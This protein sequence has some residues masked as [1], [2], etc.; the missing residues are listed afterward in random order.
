MKRIKLYLSV[1][2]AMALF[3]LFGIN[4][5]AAYNYEE[6]YSPLNSETTFVDE[7]KFDNLSVGDKNN[8]ANYFLYFLR[9]SYMFEVTRNRTIIGENNYDTF[10]T[11][12]NFQGNVANFKALLND[13]EYFHVVVKTT[14]LQTVT[15]TYNKS[16]DINFNDYLSNEY[17]N[18]DRIK[19]LEPE[20]IIKNYSSKEINIDDYKNYED[21]VL[22]KTYD[23]CE[24]YE[25]TD[26]PINLP[27]REELLNK[28]I[29]LSNG[30]KIE[31]DNN[32]I[33]GGNY[34]LDN[35]GFINPG[36]YYLKI[37]TEKNYK[38]YY[39]VYKINV[40]P[41]PTTIP[42]IYTTTYRQ[43]TTDEINKHLEDYDITNYTYD[44]S[45][46]L[47]Y[48][49]IPGSYYIDIN[50]KANGKNISAKMII[51]VNE[52]ND[53]VIKIKDN[54]L[55][56]IGYNDELDKEE[57]ENNIDFSYI[58]LDS[59]EIDYSEY[60]NNHDQIGNYNIYLYI[61]SKDGIDYIQ[62]SNIEIYDNICPS[63][64]LDDDIELTFLY[65]D[66]I[67]I[68]KI[69]ASLNIEDISDYRIIYDD[70]EFINREILIGDFTI[71]VNIIDINENNIMFPINIHVID[72]TSPKVIANNMYTTTNVL[73]DLN[74]IKLNVYAKDEID[75]VINIDNIT[76]NDANGYKDNY[77]L[78]GTYR[79]EAIITD[80]SGNEAFASFN[81]IVS[82][83]EEIIQDNNIIYI[84]KNNP[85]SKDEIIS[86]LKEK[87]YIDI[88]DEYN[89]SSIYFEC[90]TYD[91]DSYELEVENSKHEKLYFEIK[92]N[93]TNVL[94]DTIVEDDLEEDSG[95][96]PIIIIVVIAS[97]LVIASGILIFVIYKK[98]H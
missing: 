57:F 29:I 35:N 91:S 78:A 46:Y 39:V 49:Y 1:I 16:Y 68:G 50:Y 61:K 96:N 45:T 92:L 43:L 89:V 6:G 80:N 59:Y 2:A 38:T 71:N 10:T 53:Q 27:I 93:D 36:T 83:E 54:E 24:T 33:Y 8:F 82:D 87:G 13:V 62:I 21:F 58:E 75:G 41:L 76:I 55:L 56:K 34:I 72:K 20:T 52:I 63:V 74:T 98:K 65:N 95:I 18:S 40:L 9:N 31:S 85:F 11:I 97:I 66:N 86:Y 73:L 25:I 3:I 37:K 81:I 64:S 26:N 30:L 4:I 17:N 79:I 48:F 70:K 44:I 22:I 42:S 12:A 14:N 88:N 15:Y 77:N 84:D 60:E 5:H 47:K 67:D 23:V 69:V 90:D 28:E 32:E 7:I 94:Y 19:F 51:I